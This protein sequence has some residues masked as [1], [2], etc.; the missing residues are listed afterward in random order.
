MWRSVPF[1]NCTLSFGPKDFVPFEKTN[2]ISAALSLGIHCPIAWNSSIWQQNHFHQSFFRFFLGMTVNLPV[3]KSHFHR[4]CIPILFCNFDSR[5]D[6]KNHRMAS[7]TSHWWNLCTVFETSS[8]TD[9]GLSMRFSFRRIFPIALSLRFWNRRG[10]LQRFSTFVLI[11][12]ETTSVSSCALSFRFPLTAFSLLPVN[13]DWFLFASDFRWYSCL[14]SIIFSFKNFGL[15]FFDPNI[16]SPW[17]LI[18]G[19]T[20]VNCVVQSLVRVMPTRFLSWS[21]SR[22]RI[23]HQLS[24]ISTEGWQSHL[25]QI[26][27]HRRHVR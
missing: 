1:E 18:S 7:C 23:L 9:Y 26:L 20:V 8:Q 22:V 4:I 5:E 19:S 25:A 12:R 3:L 21:D 16:S 10:R 17:S 13:A 6:A 14:D 15:L 11:V 24:K 27:E 2:W